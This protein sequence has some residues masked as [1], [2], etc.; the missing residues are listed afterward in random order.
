[1][2][3]RQVLGIAAALLICAGC[4]KQEESINIAQQ[5]GIAYAPL[6]IMQSRGLLEKRLEGVRVNWKQFGG[7]TAIREGMLAGEIDIGFMGPAPALIG[8]DNGME[9]KIATG[10]SMNEVA[11]VV[12]N[13][14]VKTLADLTKED[15]IA[16]LSPACTQHV[17]LCMAAEKEF[18]DPHYL[19]SQ[20][21]S[22]S[23]PDAV[24]AL[25]SNTEITA[26]VATP[27]YIQME[28]DAGM[29]RIY[30]GAELMEGPLTFI[31]GV[32]TQ[33]F[34]QNKSRQYA[35]FLESLRE[36]IDYINAN[37][38]EAAALLA[39]E[40][41]ISEEELIAQ[42]S[43]Q[44]SIYSM[45]LMGIEELSGAMHR[46]GFLTTPLTRAE[47]AFPEVGEQE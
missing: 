35:A 29:H 3:I 41:G 24:N 34:Y 33:A 21:V 16:I 30:T 31:T 10:I 40:Y 9:W 25:L 7:P 5:Y 17:L 8:I 47:F 42:M 37:M 23:H 15:R 1:L 45:E 32:A 20:L 14:S 19:D 4:T 22:L 6:Q 2:K 46:M 28:L 11:I 13:E 26:H 43:V 44:G 38:D 12:K 39:P 27:P 18:G 36:A